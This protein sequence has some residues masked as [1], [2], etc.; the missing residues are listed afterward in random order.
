MLTGLEVEELYRRYG[1]VIFRRCRALLGQEEEAM[2]AMQDVFIRALKYGRSF[3]RGK[4]PLPWLFTIANR[5]CFDRYRA[6]KRR[7]GTLVEPIGTFGGLNPEQ[8]TAVVEFLRKFDDLTQEIIL[9]YYL[10]EMSMEEISAHVGRSRKTVG[11][12]IARFKERSQELLTRKNS[13]HE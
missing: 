2:D 8:K 3:R 9:D 13:S 4:K 1:Q 10:E 7:E 11:K 5:I 12:K 6:I